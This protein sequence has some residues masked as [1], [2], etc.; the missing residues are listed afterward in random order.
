LRNERPA[1]VIAHPGHEL[2]LFGWLCDARPD[3]FVLTDGSGHSG[4]PRIESTRRLL[5]T[6]GARPGALFGSYTDRQIYRGFLGGDPSIF[7]DMT[8]ALTR[9]LQ[10]GRYSMVV[11]DPFEGYNPGHDLCSVVGNV[12]TRSVAARLRLSIWVDSRIVIS[13]PE[14]RKSD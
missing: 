3:V 2:R 6:V 9:S 14:L 12:A 4:P 11:V 7:V 5:E 1:L 10:R 8:T 13:D